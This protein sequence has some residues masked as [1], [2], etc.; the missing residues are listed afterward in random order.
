ML[1]KGV[2]RVIIRLQCPFSLERGKDN[3]KEERQER[4]GA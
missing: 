3:A 4:K 1:K 2:A